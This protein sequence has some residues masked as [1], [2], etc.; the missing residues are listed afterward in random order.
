MKIT[1]INNSSGIVP[2]VDSSNCLPGT[3][4]V[5]LNRSREEVAIQM[6]HAVTNEVIVIAELD[7]QELDPIIC[8][9]KHPADPAGGVN[10]CAGVGYDLKEMDGTT[11]ANVQ[12]QMYLG[13]FDDAAC[14]IPAVHGTLNTAAKG[15]ID[16]GAGTNLLKCTPDAT[17]EMSVTLT[18]T[19]D[20]TVHIKAWPVG[21]NYV[22]DCSDID[23]VT[24]SA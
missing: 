19:T 24:F 1:V 17:G 20:E 10:T 23:S 13:V 16:S 14:T 18:D 3:T 4:R 22:I 12:P 11:D 21:T 9:M 15:T 5:M 2:C 8:Q 6:D 7:A